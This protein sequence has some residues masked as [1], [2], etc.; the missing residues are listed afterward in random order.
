M[1]PAS[2]ETLGLERHRELAPG[3]GDSSH[4]PLSAQACLYAGKIVATYR[5]LDELLLEARTRAARASLRIRRT[6]RCQ[7]ST[8]AAITPIRPAIEASRCTRTAGHERHAKFETRIELVVGGKEMRI[9][10][11]LLALS[12]T[13]L[14]FTPAPNKCRASS[15]RPAQR[16]RSMGNSSRHHLQISMV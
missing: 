9:G 1:V 14:G 15:A 13:V 11:S 5:L 6:P 2:S 8:S 16:L 12:L 10:I 7:P 3:E 4:A